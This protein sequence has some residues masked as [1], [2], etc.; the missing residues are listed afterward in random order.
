MPKKR[1]PQAKPSKPAPRAAQI[2]S[3]L[4]RFTPT[5]QSPQWQDANKWRWAV[6]NQPIAISCRDTL[7]SFLVGTE[8]QI[9]AKNPDETEK[10]RTDIDYYEEL[11]NNLNGLDFDS[12]LDL[13]CQDILDTP[14][15]GAA[16]VGRLGDVPEGR[17]VWVQNID[18]A[19]LYPTYDFE[20]PVAQRVPGIL[21]P[22]VLFPR[23][24]IDRSYLSPRPEYDRK[25]W[26]M[27]PPE[28]IYLA[29]DLLFRG[30]RYYA[31][32]LLDTPEA[33]IL[34]LLDMDKEAAL[35]WLTS[36]QT[37]FTGADPF[38]VP[39][40]YEHTTKAEWIPFGRPPTE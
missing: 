38:K 21:L 23:H 10:Y 2:P 40:L 6:R 30:D 36:F 34:D 14:F 7:I 17:V 19:T 28:K 25:G 16:E 35:E 39:V 8:W 26:G 12:F 11:F 1:K 13:L 37:L 5:F 15:G 20:F 9:R 32:L 33:G 22:P 4:L 29:I 27:A 24:A 31:N 18:S 3:F